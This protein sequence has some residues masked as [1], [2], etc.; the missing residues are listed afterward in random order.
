MLALAALIAIGLAPDGITLT[1]RATPLPNVL[2]ELGK[3]TGELLESTPQFENE[4][5]LV[6]VNGL[7]AEAVLSAIASATA[8]KW[9]KTA[10]G[11]RLVPDSAARTKQERE[12]LDAKVE[13]FR[14]QIKEMG[15]EATASKESAGAAPGEA[16]TVEVAPASRSNYISSSK[17]FAELLNGVNPRTLASVPVGGRV[18]FSTQPTQMQG[19]LGANA[20]QVI[21]AL[22]AQHNEEVKGRANAAAETAGNGEPEMPAFMRQFVDRYTK[23]IASVSKANLVYVRNL[24]EFAQVS[25]EIYDEKGQTAYNAQQMLGDGFRAFGSD[26]PEKPTTGPSTPIELSPESSAIRGMQPDFRNG[27]VVAGKRPATDV[28]ARLRN[29]TATDPLSLF[30]TDKLLGW[31]TAKKKNIV[32]VL[33]DTML[34]QTFGGPAA[35]ATVED[36]QREL[37]R[38]QT[39][40]V[41]ENGGITIASPADPVESRRNRVNRR[42]LNVLLEA[43]A[44]KG[45][46]G[47]LDISEF[48]KTSPSPTENG[49]LQVYSI[50]FLP[51]LITLATI[52]GANWDGV[53]L[54]GSLGVLPRK[55]L[56][57]G[58]SIPFSSLVGAQLLPVLFGANARPVSE[59]AGEGMMESMMAMMGGGSDG[60]K[61]EVTELMPNGIPNAGNLSAAVAE[62]FYATE[63]GEGDASGVSMQRPLGA[64]ELALYRLYTQD[65]SMAAMSAFMPKLKRLKVGKRSRWTLSFRI[66]EDRVIRQTLYDHRL[67]G[68][69][70][71]SG[72]S[73]PAE[74]EAEVAKKLAELKKSPLGSLGEMMRRGGQGGPPPVN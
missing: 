44:Q 20:S 67:Q 16:A 57:D 56:A 63:A 52:D 47:L 4:V 64:D 11:R 18:V 37:S 39:L 5:V 73:L 32:A 28:L 29:V 15:A 53:R 48:A 34:A 54:F 65:K 14:K 41:I 38:A 70:I 2:A 24:A 27:Q 74:F 43:N 10:R 68:G 42:A 35:A 60:Y 12:A 49:V 55:A 71:V 31:A 61:S 3:Q 21:A 40:R 17:I 23:P 58:K 72:D 9:E 13:S 30:P 7:P 51:E 46:A 1:M 26:E 50:A 45:I 33:P 59:T 22:V 19:Q 25:L 8:G 62:E 6:R 69:A 66:S 36:V